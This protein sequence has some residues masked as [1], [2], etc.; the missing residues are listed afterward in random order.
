MGD[1]WRQVHSSF[2]ALCF[3][4]LPFTLALPLISHVPSDATTSHHATHRL[5]EAS[6]LR[7]VSRFITTFSCGS[8][9]WL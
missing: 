9:R 3:P 8:V 6:L 5:T 2:N 1:D 4:P 7:I